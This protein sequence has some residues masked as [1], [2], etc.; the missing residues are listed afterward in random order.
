MCGGKPAGAKGSY[1]SGHA[2][3]GYLSAIVLA[4]M[5]PEKGDALRAR[6]DDYA[7]SRVV[8]GDHDPTDAVGSKEAAEILIG[9]M[10]D[11]P[12]FQQKYTAAKAEARQAFGL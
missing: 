6:A 7:H 8:C 2:T 12:R 10:F 1:P 9:N 3:V 4:M 11:S 5:A